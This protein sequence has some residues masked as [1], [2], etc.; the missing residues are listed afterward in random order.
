MLNRRWKLL[1]VLVIWLASM[2]ALAL[3]LSSGQQERVDIGVGTKGSESFELGSA[4]AQVITRSE[5]GISAEVFETGGSKA[6][7]DLLQKGRID[8]GTVQADT[9]IP[10]GIQAVAVMYRDAYHL[11]VREEAGIDH[12]SELAGK[13]VAIPPEASAQNGSFWFLAEHYGVADAIDAQAMGEDAANFAMIQGLVDAVFRV[14]VPGNEGVDELLG[15]AGMTL[16]PIRQAEA[17]T[18]KQPALGRGVIPKGSYRGHPP[19]PETDLPTANLDR[20]LVTREDLPANLVYRVTRDLFEHRSDVVALSRLGGQIGPLPD[21]SEGN[22]PAHPGARRYYDREKPGILQQNARLASALLY[23]IVIF[24]SGLVAVRTHWQRSRRVRMA[25]FNERLMDIADASRASEDPEE[26]MRAK[27]KL[28]DIL[29]EVVH[30]LD[31]ERVSQSEF[32]HFSFTW[33]AVDA[34]VRDKLL[35]QGTTNTGAQET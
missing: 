11:I 35:F 7:L 23:A 2:V 14:R 15:D 3:W 34:L 20:I 19:L 33:Q 21:D 9:A 16:V 24:F 18:L 5:N 32:E 28:M 29:G 25:D 6:N 22:I 8:F 12:F 17:L 30:D 27:L 31:H 26:L 1:L 13:R 4:I 10:E